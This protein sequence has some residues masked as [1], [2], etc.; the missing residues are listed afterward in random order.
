MN[1]IIVTVKPPEDEE[2]FLCAVAEYPKEGPLP[3]K[4]IIPRKW[5]GQYQRR[6]VEVDKVP[7]FIRKELVDEGITHLALLTGPLESD[8]G[9]MFFGE[10][11]RGDSVLLWF[12]ATTNLYHFFHCAKCG[13]IGVFIL[14]QNQEKWRAQRQAPQPQGAPN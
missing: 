11:V 13:S 14:D 9:F 12:N 1:N 4:E 8:E 6:F 5:Q 2:H 10:E 7:Y 3:A